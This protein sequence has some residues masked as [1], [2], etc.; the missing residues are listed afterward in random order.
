MALVMTAP[1]DE[2]HSVTD[3]SAAAWAGII[4][5][6]VFMMLEMGMVWMLMGE[7]PWAP[8]HM[9]A[10]MALGK[11]VLPPPGTYAPFDMKILVTAMMIHF[12]LSVVY[13]LVI[14]WLVH[15]FDWIGGLA[16]GVLFGVA[17]YIVN[18][19]LIA[20]MMFPWFQMAQNWISAFSHAMFGAVAGGAYIGLRKPK[21]VRPSRDT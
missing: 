3:W 2:L 4:A 18:F 7:S 15:R 8:P 17:I 1:R 12:P 10:A 14:G 13:G 19:Y 20:P 6:A 11:D 9:I 21:A 16:I 5:G